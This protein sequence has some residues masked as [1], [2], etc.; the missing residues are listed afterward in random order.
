[1]NTHVDFPRLERDWGIHLQAQDYLPA[2]FRRNFAMALDAQPTLVTSGNSGIP[3]WMTQ[4]VDPDVVRILQAPNKGADILGEKKEGDWTTQTAIFLVVENTGEVSSY[5]DHNT[6]GI[7]DANVNF[8]QRQSYLYQTIVE[9]GDLEVARVGEARLNWV[10]EKQTSAALTLSKFED[11]TYHNGVAGLQNYGLLNDPSLS[12]PLTPSTKA[13]GGTAWVLANGTINATANEVYADIQAMFYKIVS[14]SNGR[15]EAEDDLT[16]ALPPQSAVG[17]TATNS[18][19]LSVGDLL[20]KNFPKLKIKTSPRY[21]TAGGNLV[22]LIADKF[23][24]HDTGYCAFNEKMRDHAI[25][26][27][28]SAWKQKKTSGTW[29]AVIRYPV[30]ISQMLGV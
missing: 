25:V 30:A 22:Q 6:N 11:Y 21:A 14:Q 10:S 3:A 20:K 23:D 16:L 13:A 15:I 1:M 5:G 18:F 29:G 8:P 19:G 2:E 26:R 12:T 24:G 4:Y 9:Y 28:L 7:S 17:L 27:E